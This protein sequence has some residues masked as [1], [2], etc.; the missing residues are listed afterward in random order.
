MWSS[1][2]SAG[3][4]FD[5]PAKLV[6]TLKYRL[7]PKRSTRHGSSGASMRLGAWSFKV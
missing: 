7:L 1:T 3:M 6:E 4:R 5:S 2:V